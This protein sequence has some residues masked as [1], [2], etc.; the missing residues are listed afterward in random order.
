MVLLLRGEKE[1]AIEKFRAALLMNPQNV[2]AITFLGR[3]TYQQHKL[4]EA[5]DI[6]RRALS[7][8]DQDRGM[9]PVE[10]SVIRQ[11]LGDALEA[12]GQNDAAASQYSDA[13]R[14]NPKNVEARYAYGSLLAKMNKKVEA[15]SQFGT[16]INQY[17]PSHVESHISLARLQTEVGNLRAARAN[18][19]VATQL[20][21]RAPGLE[22]AAKL[23]SNAFEASTRPSTTRSAT[24]ATRSSSQP[25][26]TAPK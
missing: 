24:R 25:A 4:P 17:D 15:A 9:G 18:L 10:K 13:I 22:Q 26:A 20:N 14:L 7:M 23:W 8:A 2:N 12:K 16:I 6:L 19:V 5:E 1:P 21:P 11:Y 3:A